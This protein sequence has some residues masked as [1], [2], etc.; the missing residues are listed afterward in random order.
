MS[1]LLRNPCLRAILVCMQASKSDASSASDPQALAS[2]FYATCF[3]LNMLVMRDMF[4]RLGE[5]DLSPTQFKMLNRLMQQ[6]DGELDLSVKALGE[7]H[8]LSLAAASRAVESLHQSGYVERRECPADRRM[9]RVRITDAGREA[10]RQ[11]HAVNIE[12][13]A[14]FTKS[15]SERQRRDLAHAIVPLMERLDLPAAMDGRAAGTASPAA[16]P[17][18][19]AAA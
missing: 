8:F 4:A 9:K 6:R 14:E 3:T 19:P 17:V 11:V 12:L 10:L 13:L 16:T 5:R 7:C 15:L 18:T 2:D 1:L